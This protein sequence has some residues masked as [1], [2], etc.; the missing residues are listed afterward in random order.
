[1]ELTTNP[2][3]AA[4]K[5][6][7]IQYGFWLGL[8]NAYSAEIC[9]GSGFDWLLIDGEHAPNT[10]DTILHQLQVLAGFPVHAVVRPVE[11]TNANIKQLLDIGARNLLIPMIESVGQAQAMV[12]ACR[13]PPNG[14]RGVGTALARAADWNRTE[15]YLKRADD[16]I[17]LLLQV[18]SQ[19]G[20]DALDDIL[21][22][23]GVDG[24]FIGPADLAADLG[25]IGQ[26]AHPEVKRIVS[27]ALRRIRAAGRAPGILATDQTLVEHYKNCGALFI[28]VGVDTVLLA[29]AATSLAAHYKNTDESPLP[30]SNGAY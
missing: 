20:L 28:A 11:G 5:N 15:N 14:V 23:E 4:L 10:L 19:K 18:E 21:Q 25:H 22:T 16:E 9:A 13:Y 6:D 27:G 7:E 24:V 29:N 30:P 17:C 12:E 26:P 8:A 1:M 3:K 2:F